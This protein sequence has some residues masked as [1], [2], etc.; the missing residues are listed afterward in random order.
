MERTSNHTTNHKTGSCHTFPRVNNSKT[1]SAEAL[2]KSRISHR[3]KSLRY[4]RLRHEDRVIVQSMHNEWFPIKYEDSFFWAMCCPA[5]FDE[6]GLKGGMGDRSKDHVYDVGSSSLRNLK[7]A[8]GCPNYFRKSRYHN[9]MS[10]GAFVRDTSS[11]SSG[12][13]N[14]S[15]SNGG[16]GKVGGMK[17]KSGGATLLTAE[18]R[19]DPSSNR[20][21]TSS[22]DIGGCFYNGSDRC[23]ACIVSK[24]SLIC[25]CRDQNLV[26]CPDNIARTEWQVEYLMT[27]VSAT[28]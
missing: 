1:L 18:I 28:P 21:N 24:R 14:I 6:Q 8:C 12:R 2:T 23:I 4:G 22:S 5:N 26:Y 17:D 10:L 9:M 25:E 11:N 3:L 16:V 20:P 19:S 27:L 7:C 15:D 13:S